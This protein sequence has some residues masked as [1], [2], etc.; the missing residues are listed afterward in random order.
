MVE[1]T[2]SFQTFSLDCESIYQI[3][4]IEILS[5]N[6]FDAKTTMII[7]WSLKSVV[8]PGFIFKEERG[9][10]ELFTKNMELL[11]SSRP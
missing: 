5:C 7:Y 1:V 4:F 11:F 9:G 3:E 2:K 6:G 8:Y 10:Y